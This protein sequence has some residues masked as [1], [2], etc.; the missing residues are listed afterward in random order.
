MTEVLFLRG[1]TFEYQLRSLFKPVT[2]KINSSS[3]VELQGK[4]GSGKSTLLRIIAGFLEPSCGKILWRTKPI[5]EALLNYQ[6]QITL[7]SYQNG[8]KLALTVEEN[9][10]LM[11]MLN[12][13][14]LTLSLLNEFLEQTHLFNFKKMPVHFLS[15]GQKRRLSL[16]RLWFTTKKIWLLDEPTHALDKEGQFFLLALI[17]RQLGRGG[18][19]ITA[20]HD[21]LPFLNKKIVILEQ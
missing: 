1:I 6:Q 20:T 12:E 7:L 8:L 3:Y 21:P 11:C 18:I 14:S 15:E 2:L 13:I 4:N 17:E 19:I 16:A 9:L 10:H 5:M